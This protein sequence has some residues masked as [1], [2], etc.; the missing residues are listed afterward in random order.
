MVVAREDTQAKM[1]Q[2]AA[3]TLRHTPSQRYTVADRL[4]EKARAHPARPFILYEGT[5]LD[6]ATV[7]A[8]ANRVAHALRARGVTTE[9]VAALLME[10]R[11]EFIVTWLALAKLGVTVALI[12]TQ[13]RGEV[14]RHALATTDAQAVFVGSE[15]LPALAGIPQGVEPGAADLRRRGSSGSGNRVA[16]RRGRRRARRPRGRDAGERSRR[17]RPRPPAQRRRPLLH[18]HLRHDRAA[19]GRALQA[20]ELSPRA[21]LAA[22]AASAPPA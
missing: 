4:E 20:H 7:N 2:L 8:R 12:N 19:Q 10:N 6:Y 17:R 3:A 16:C 15:L 14:L 11:P 5:T 13:L 1:D 21:R 9:R 18:L 22:V